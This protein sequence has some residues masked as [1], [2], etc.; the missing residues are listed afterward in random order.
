MMQ[1]LLVDDHMVVREG[2][3][4]MLADVP[5]IVVA[6]EAEHAQG[7][8]AALASASYDLVLLDISLPDGGNGFDILRHLKETYPT[9][10][11]L[12][13]SVHPERQYVI[14]ALQAGAA[15]YLLKNSAPQEL[16]TALWQVTQGKQYISTALVGHL[17]QAIREPNGPVLPPLSPRELQVL[18]LLAAGAAMK[19]IAYDL[20]ISAKTVS[21]YRRRLLQKLG[22]R[23]TAD[24]IR[25][26]VEQGA[27]HWPPAAV[28]AAQRLCASE[29][30]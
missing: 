24:L 13:F 20:S 9:L 11:V 18:R 23:T 3:K 12:I 8:Y 15:G 17:V 27:V 19:E 16:I 10:P 25:Y 2:V 26:A 5:D 14:R 4:R 21:T 28:N 30:E 22:L 29:Q 6:G 7:A 1:L